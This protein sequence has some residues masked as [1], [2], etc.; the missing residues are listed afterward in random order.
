MVED[1]L[2]LMERWSKDETP[3]ALLINDCTQTLGDVRIVGVSFEEQSVTVEM[4]DGT[5]GEFGLID[6]EMFQGVNS[7]TLAEYADLGWRNALAIRLP[8]GTGRRWLTFAEPF[9][10][11]PTS[12]L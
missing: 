5:E 9:I 12:E 4:D 1:G 2:R 7:E 3:V 11:E 6:T 10:S 8:A